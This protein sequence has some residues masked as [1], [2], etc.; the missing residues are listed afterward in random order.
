MSDG[1]YLELLI[2][3]EVPGRDSCSEKGYLE[4]GIF[5]K[6]MGPPPRGNQTCLNR[7]HGYETLT[8]ADNGRRRNGQGEEVA[9]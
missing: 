8:A 7:R 5:L 4:Y 1:M 6:K 3:G 9:L 2:A